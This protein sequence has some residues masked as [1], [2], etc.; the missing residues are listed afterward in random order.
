[1]AGSVRSR[2]ITMMWMAELSLRS[3]DR[4]SRWRVVSPDD[5]GERIA[6]GAHSVD[7]IGLGALSTR[8]PLG[9]IKFDHH[10]ASLGLVL[11]GRV[12]PF[13]E[14]IIPIVDLV[15]PNFER[16]QLLGRGRLVM[17]CGARL[18]GE[19]IGLPLLHLVNRRR[20]RHC[21]VVY[22]DSAFAGVISHELSIPGR[23][24]P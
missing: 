6:C 5:A 9:T 1:V 2:Q 7:R 18:L 10:F 21:S 13:D 8:W 3:P 14:Q 23:P 12:W 24:T 16:S 17:H 19:L 20:I 11:S 15:T 22:G 4:L